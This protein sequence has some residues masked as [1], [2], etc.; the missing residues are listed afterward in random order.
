M[1]SYIIC[2]DSFEADEG[3]MTN[4]VWK[5]W[6][7]T[8]LSHFVFLAVFALIAGCGG[9]GTSDN[10][11]TATNPSPPVAAPPTPGIFMLAGTVGGAGSVDGAQGRFNQPNGLALDAIGDGYVA[12]TLN[13]TIRKISGTGVV[14]IAGLPGASGS[15]D[16]TGSAAR[17]NAPVAIARDTAGNFYVTEA[18]AIRKVT[19]AGVVTTLA[20]SGTVAG[21]LDGDG[22]ASRFR[23]PTGIA[24]DAAGFIFVADKGNKTIRKVS[25][26]GTV[27]T[28]AGG[29]DSPGAFGSIDGIGSLAH[30]VDPTGIAVAPNGLVYVTDKQGQLIRKISLGNVVTTLAGTAGGTSGSGF[31]DGVGS[32][33]RFNF[34]SALAMDGSGNLIVTDNANGMIRKVTPDGMVTTVP[35]NRLFRFGASDAGVVVGSAGQIYVSES[36][37]NVITE[38]TPAGSTRRI[39]GTSVD[40]GAVDGTA[41][42]A[43][44]D[45][46]SGIVTDAAGNSYVVDTGNNTVRKITPA[47]VVSTVAGAAGVGSE[48]VDGTG[49]TAR[50]ALP[51]GIAISIDGTLF[52]AD[53][54]THLIRR[55]SPTGVV[56]T[57]AGS[58]WPNGVGFLGSGRSKPESIAMDGGGTIYVV[59][60]LNSIRKLTP[61]TNG[62]TECPAPCFPP[63]TVV[64]AQAVA[65]DREGNIYVAELYAITRITPAGVA[66]ILAGNRQSSGFADGIGAA[67]SFKLP[68]SIALDSTGNIYVADT[69]NNAIRKVTQDGVVTTVA[70]RIGSTGVILGP[71]PGSLAAPSGIAVGPGGVLLVTTENAVVKIQQ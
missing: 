18:A 61:S 23:N 22:T 40:S 62:Y 49:P 53:L 38:V 69:G 59:D 30:F 55:I 63:G 6:Q 4:A 52:V 46:P 19:P 44:F 70:G 20:G 17:F 65:V 21:N 13:H 66:T 28:I 15:V 16:G 25:P 58:D 12:D 32:N 1:F 57:I 35:G 71:L 14:T 8:S 39:Q 5:S 67:A 37:I 33:A 56:T 41:A 2:P 50:F 60:A 27:T 51:R 11:M 54:G 68:Q 64:A 45:R 43:R 47:G 29:P 9:G 36:E 42:N 24:V 10:P 31:I 34:P 3:N 7:R 48:S 26:T